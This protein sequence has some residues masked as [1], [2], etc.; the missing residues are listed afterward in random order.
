MSNEVKIVEIVDYDYKEIEPLLME[1]VESIYGN[2]NKGMKKYEEF[3][4]SITFYKNYRKFKTENKHLYFVFLKDKLTG[5]FFV[6]DYPD[7]DYVYLVDIVIGKRYR[8]KGIGKRVISFIE[9]EF[10]KDIVTEAHPGS[11]NFFLA[12]GFVVKSEAKG[13][14]GILWYKMRKRLS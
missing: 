6:V 10:S 14:D 9:K 7:R 3:Y 2:V 13:K 1:L 12:N 5:F 8:G 11:L 4:Q